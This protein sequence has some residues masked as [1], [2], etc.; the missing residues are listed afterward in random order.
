MKEYRRGCRCDLCKVANKTY[1]AEY[2]ERHRKEVDKLADYD[3]GDTSWVDKAKCKGQDTNI[4]FPERGDNR[5][6]DKA[7]SFCLNC[8]V[9]EN[10]LSYAIRTEQTVGVWGNKSTRERSHMLYLIKKG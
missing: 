5:L 6:I 3:E 4:F 2:R 7:K 8:E 10:C 9:V 1:M